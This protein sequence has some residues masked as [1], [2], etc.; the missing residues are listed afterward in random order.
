MLEG[1]IKALCLPDCFQVSARN[2][3]VVITYNV[4]RTTLGL[5]AVQQTAAL[6]HDPAHLTAANQQTINYGP[7]PFNSGQSA[8][9]KIQAAFICWA[10]MQINEFG[11]NS[12]AY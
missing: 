10:K 4:E 7:D 1:I 2:I 9:D 12:F 5:Q 8:D 11:V 3:N 6:C